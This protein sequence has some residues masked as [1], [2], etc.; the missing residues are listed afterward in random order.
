M[1]YKGFIAELALSLTLLAS[2]AQAATISIVHKTPVVNAALP[3]VSKQAIARMPL[4]DI[5]KAQLEVKSMDSLSLKDLT[6]LSTS[7]GGEI[8]DMVAVPVTVAVN[9]PAGPQV[10]SHSLVVTQTTAG[11]TNVTTASTV[12]SAVHT[13][14]KLQEKK[15]NGMSLRE[16]AMQLVPRPRSNTTTIPGTGAATT[17]STTPVPPVVPPPPPVVPV[18]VPVVPITVMLDF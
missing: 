3:A 8:S 13:A 1:K 10:T 12:Q 9:V 11:T 16:Q 5:T 6:E 18:V 4:V 7:A 2:G 15:L 14:I 17:G